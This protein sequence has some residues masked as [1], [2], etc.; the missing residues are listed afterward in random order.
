MSAY[1][2]FIPLHRWKSMCKLNNESVKMR[3]DAL[4]KCRYFFQRRK[5]RIKSRILSSHLYLF[6]VQFDTTMCRRRCT[7]LVQIIILILCGDLLR[8]RQSLFSYAIACRLSHHSPL[9][10]KMI[11]LFHYFIIPFI[12]ETTQTIKCSF[13]VQRLHSIMV[14]LDTAICEDWTDGQ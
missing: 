5:T 10:W 1:F 13:C 14:A 6:D 7:Y 8:V 2:P 11:S 4:F 3:F 12:R 9:I